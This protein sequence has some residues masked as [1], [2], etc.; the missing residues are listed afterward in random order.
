MRRSASLEPQRAVLR[1]LKAWHQWDT[2]RYKSLGNW[3]MSKAGLP[4]RPICPSKRELLSLSEYF[5]PLRRSL[6]II[7][8]DIGEGRLESFEADI[9]DVEKC[10][11]LICS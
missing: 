7:V 5:F 4:K 6:K 11:L 2:N 3:L 1:K 8:C 10:K 9:L